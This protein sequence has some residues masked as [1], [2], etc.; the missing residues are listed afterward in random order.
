MAAVVLQRTTE[1]HFQHTEKQTISLHLN[2]Y[3]IV[4]VFSATM[5]FLRHS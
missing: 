1:L 3:F 2:I 4:D 5:L